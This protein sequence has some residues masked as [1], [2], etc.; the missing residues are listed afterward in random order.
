MMNRIFLG[1]C[2]L[3]LAQGVSAQQITL[4]SYN[5]L[6]FPEGNIPGREDTLR[7]IID[8]VQ[9]DLFLIQELESDS[10]LQLILNESFANLS[11]NYEATTFVPQ[12]SNPTSDHP[13]QQAMVYNADL[14]GMAHE[15]RLM[16]S[17]RDIN[18]FKLFWKPSLPSADTL[19]LYVFVTHLKS[20][21]G[22]SNAEARLEMVQTLTTHFQYLPDNSPV[23]FAGD[24]N[25]YT[26]DEPA[27]QELL[28]NTN[29]IVLQDPIDAPG[30]WHNSSF[31]PKSVLTQSTRSSG[32][33]GDGAGGGL[34]DRFDFVLLSSDMFSGWNTINYQ[35][36]SYSAFGNS[37]NCYDQSITNCS[38][39]TVSSDMRKSL[40]N[41]SDHLP[42]VL[43]LN[44]TTEYLSVDQSTLD[45]RKIGQDVRGNLNINWNK[46]EA[47]ELRLIDMAGRTIVTQS[48]ALV[49]GNNR[50]LNPFPNMETG[51]YVLQ[52]AGSNGNL[53]GKVILGE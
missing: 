45:F 23:I 37:G 13:L 34:D 50:V 19:F 43:E 53:S 51:C 5:V 36:D 15:G 44:I 49:K 16:T 11:A 20:S 24:F 12:Q 26:S 29:A 18:R 8:V 28:D 14:F 40:Y 25:L 7:T 10:G 32:I 48:A 1:F 4:M 22:N 21:Q 47:V 2:L 52:I 30:N 17:V 41:M 27:Y 42:I 35:E 9:P 6:N 46:N 31:Q 33:F 39:G 38:G 3:V